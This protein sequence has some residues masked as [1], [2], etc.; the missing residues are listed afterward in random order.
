MEK[1]LIRELTT[2][3]K[4]AKK[5]A[6]IVAKRKELKSPYSNFSENEFKFLT[7]FQYYQIAHLW[8]FL[9]RHREMDNDAVRKLLKSNHKFS[10]LNKLD[11]LFPDMLD[12]LREHG[13]TCVVM[14]YEEYKASNL[15]S[16]LNLP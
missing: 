1:T 12:E 15:N 8:Y 4:N 9:G 14:K 13:P 7:D 2:Y 10:F 6:D 16:K 11:K 5:N 3:L